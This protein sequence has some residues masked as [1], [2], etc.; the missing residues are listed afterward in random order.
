[1]LN[2]RIVVTVDDRDILVKMR[3]REMTLA[4][5]RLHGFGYVDDGY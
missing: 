5:G 2:A 4:C 1:M 3:T